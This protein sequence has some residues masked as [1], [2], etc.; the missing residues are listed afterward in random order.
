MKVFRICSFLFPIMA[1]A[2]IKPTVTIV[3]GYEPAFNQ[4]VGEILSAV[5]LETNRIS[6]GIGQIEA[7]KQYFTPEGFQDFSTIVSKTH[8]YT[9]KKDYKLNVVRIGAK[10]L[11]EV[12]NIRVNVDVGETEANPTQ[13]LVF[14]FNEKPLI[15]GLRYSI[16]SHNYD[17][18]L[19]DGTSV[20]DS[21]CRQ[22]V[23]EF[24]EVY[25]T[26]YHRKDADFLEKIFSDDA[27]IISGSVAYRKPEFN[28]LTSV[29]SQPP[30]KVVYYRQFSKVEYINRLREYIF[31]SNKYIN[32]KFEDIEV[33][34][35]RT[36]DKVYGVKLKQHW[37]AEKYEDV[38]YLFLTVYFLKPTEPLILVRVWQDIDFEGDYDVSIYDFDIV[39]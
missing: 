15:C 36:Q 19:S 18:I 7:V 29:A 13:Y 28:D 20:S 31:P 35:H 21:L 12:R 14:S 9:S 16:P 22:Q 2:Q 4:K 37:K 34:H 39:E 32:L 10:Q 26:A 30:E 38:G 24:L 25:A 27:L 1:L 23:I 6:R 11:F 3:G 33:M 8:P 17:E 5:L